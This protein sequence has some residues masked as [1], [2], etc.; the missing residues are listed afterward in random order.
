[1][2]EDMNPIDVDLDGPGDFFY[3]FSELRLY[4]LPEELRISCALLGAMATTMEDPTR[5]P[6]QKAANWVTE[7]LWAIKELETEFV[8]LRRELAGGQKS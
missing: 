6:Y 2:T 3:P 4:Q 7:C 8:A 1:M 5:T